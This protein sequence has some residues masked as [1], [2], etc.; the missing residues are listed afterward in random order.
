MR[1]RTPSPPR[2]AGETWSSH[3]EARGDQRKD[4]SSQLKRYQELLDIAA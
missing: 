3:G 4:S 1:R 2:S